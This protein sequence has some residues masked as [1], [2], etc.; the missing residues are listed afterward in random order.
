[1]NCKDLPDTRI[2]FGASLYCLSL[3]WYQGVAFLSSLNPQRI[4]VILISKVSYY[5]LDSYVFVCLRKWKKKLYK[6]NFL[7]YCN[8]VL[9]VL[10]L[11][12]VYD[13]C[14]ALEIKQ[15]NY[16]QLKDEC[17]LWNKW[18]PGR[19]FIPSSFKTLSI[20]MKEF[21]DSCWG[22]NS[23]IEKNK[24]KSFCGYHIRGITNTRMMLI[25]RDV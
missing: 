8:M 13:K 11:S 2:G 4:W 6:K 15:A 1:M 20:Y 9:E 24:K 25:S 23:Q 10:Y 12:G 18:T 16:S 19:A 5:V 22:S 3:L 21:E 7:K 14:W 17:K